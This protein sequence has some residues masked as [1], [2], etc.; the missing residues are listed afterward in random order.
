MAHDTV[1]MSIPFESLLSAVA[2]LSL[3]DKQRLFQLL[4]EEIAQAEEAV[5][6]RD[7]V[8]QEEVQEARAAYQAGDFITIDDYISQLNDKP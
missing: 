4:E 6:E 5:W 2:H 1:E 7:P 3:E 8:I